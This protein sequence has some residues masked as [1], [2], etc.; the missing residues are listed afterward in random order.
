[1][2]CWYPGCKGDHDK[3]L[4][5]MHICAPPGAPLVY[6]PTTPRFTG[7]EFT[8]SCGKR[9]VRSRVPGGWDRG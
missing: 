9:W 6:L 4:Y 5:P 7:P 1:M 3:Y 2:T 8:C